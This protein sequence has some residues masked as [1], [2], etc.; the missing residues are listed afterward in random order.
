MQNIISYIITAMSDFSRFF[1]IVDE[2]YV[3]RHPFSVSLGKYSPRNFIIIYAHE[4]GFLLDNS[5]WQ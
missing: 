2:L 3:D 5:R 4:K 1:K